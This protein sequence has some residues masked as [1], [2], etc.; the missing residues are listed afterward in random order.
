MT[1]R[2]IMI[3]LNIVL[4]L[5]MLIHVSVRMYLHGQHEEYSSPIYVELVYSVYYLVP[6][7]VINFVNRFLQKK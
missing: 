4:V 5:S 1:R 6:L 7:L 3:V 2:K